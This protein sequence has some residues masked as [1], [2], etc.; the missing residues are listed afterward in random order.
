MEIQAFLNHLRSGPG[1]A[2]Q[3]AHIEHLPPRRARYAALDE[4]LLPELQASLDA[5]G[6]SR[7][8]AHQAE[9]VNH[10]RQ[11]KNVII[12]TSSASGKTLCYNIAVMQTLLTEPG[13]RAIYLFPT[14]ALAQDQLRKLHELFSPGLLPPEALATFDGDTPRSERADVRRQGR[15]ILTNPDML[16]VG[17]LPN[18]Q[19]WAG[20]LRRLRYVVVD[21]AHIYRGVFGSHVAG[22]LRPSLIPASTPCA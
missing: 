14:K 11:G 16:H 3:I 7:L 1:Y 8:Y 4:P 20:L 22:V 18:H 10:S 12:A 6:L 9:A 15:I 17:I 21:E 13:S 5:N 2:N 19:A